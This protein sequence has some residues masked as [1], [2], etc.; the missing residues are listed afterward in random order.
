VPS[1]SRGQVF[2]T[3]GI[4][5]DPHV[6][7]VGRV[8]L[9]VEAGTASVHR[10]EVEVR[11]VEVG[12]RLRVE[13]LLGHRGP[14]QRVVVDELAEIRVSGQDRRTVQR[15][16]A[17]V[18][19]LGGQHVQQLVRGA[20]VGESLNLTPKR[21]SVSLPA[22]STMS[23]P[24]GSAFACFHGFAGA[25][26]GSMVVSSAAAAGG[27]EQRPPSDGGCRC[28]R[29][30]DHATAGEPSAPRV[31]LVVGMNMTA[32]VGHGWVMGTYASNQTRWQPM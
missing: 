19:H 3:L 12:Q 11:A 9:G 10:R 7:G 29:A 27:A 17:R 24:R 15:R 18:G 6:H 13:L 4:A 1:S 28:A 30:G 14:V 21:A 25:G 5:N 2:H 8:E 32:L 31:R 22:V 16:P 26:A 23:L 20:W